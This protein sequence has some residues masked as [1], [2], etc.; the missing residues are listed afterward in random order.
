MINAGSLNGDGERKTG[1]VR[2]PVEMRSDDGRPRWDQTNGTGMDEIPPV[3]GYNFVT[4]FTPGAG[5]VL[6]DEAGALTGEL[7]LHTA[8]RPDGQAVLSVSDTGGEDWYTVTG[9]Y[10]QLEDLSLAEDL[11]TAAVALLATGGADARDLTLG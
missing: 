8:V 9:G 3:D 6:T 2:H 11:H 10:Y 1:P 5:G 4:G 7:T